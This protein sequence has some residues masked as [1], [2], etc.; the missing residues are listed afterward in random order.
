[1]YSVLVVGI[2]Y[3]IC[4]GSADVLSLFLSV[5]IVNTSLG[6]SFKGMDSEMFVFF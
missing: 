1:M 3:R 6:S 2:C 4:T 5:K